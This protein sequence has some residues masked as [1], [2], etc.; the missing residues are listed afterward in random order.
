MVKA[1]RHRENKARVVR[2]L[3]KKLSSS[4]SSLFSLT[5]FIE[6]AP[7][8]IILLSFYTAGLVQAE[9]FPSYVRL[10]L[11]LILMASGVLGLRTT[12]VVVMVTIAAGEAVLTLAG[13]TGVV[14]AIAGGCGL[15]LCATAI[16][17]LARTRML[18]L[19][20]SHSKTT[21]EQLEARLSLGERLAKGV[22]PN[23][24]PG[25]GQPV[26]D[27][28]GLVANLILPAKKALGSRTAVFYW[29]NDKDD[30]LVPVESLSDCP[31]LLSNAPI[32]L[33]AGRLSGLKTSREPTAFRF[34]P[35]E[36]HDLP[37]YKKRVELTGLLT[38]PIHHRGA[39]AAALVLDRVGPQP[40]FLPET[41]I[42]RRLGVMV[43]ESLVTER[44]LKSAILLSQQLRMM[45]EAARQFSTARTFDQVYD[46]AV[47]HAVA[48]S[49][50]RTAVL[51]HRVNTSSDEY[52]IV[53]VNRKQFAGLLGE[54][55][56]V[57]GTLCESAARARTH[58]P[59]NFVFERRMPQ[60]FG[61]NVGIELEEDEPC[62]LIPLMIRDE[63]V[64]FLLLAE[65]ERAV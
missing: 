29:Y 62:L 25:S 50:F 59:P 37:I 13:I 15:V 11:G 4:S 31:E 32:S 20:A 19:S 47:R 17:V 43:E 27:T 5:S 18:A 22:T 8:L 7:L 52:E 56:P 33:R 45:D 48:F 2:R 61:K 53:A 23:P 55:F 42:A 46:T 9:V 21:R 60:P 14:E 63:A 30:S 51:A 6:Y 10:F 28:E 36:K 65:N 40:Y 24:T 12:S 39:L 35:H 16:P 41:V 58:L 34:N 57:R 26:A 38:I 54:R 3:K 49:P 64:G 1:R 44:R